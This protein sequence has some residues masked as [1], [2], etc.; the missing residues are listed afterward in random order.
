MF[1]YISPPSA[2]SLGFS[3]LRWPWMVRWHHVHVQNSQQHHNLMQMKDL[4]QLVNEVEQNIVICPCRRQRQIIDLRAIYKSWYYATTEFNNNVLSFTYHIASFYIF[5][6]S[7][8]ESSAKRAAI[9]YE[10]E[11]NAH[12]Q[13][14][15]CSWGMFLANAHAQTIICTQLF[16]DKLTNQNWE[17]NKVND[18]NNN[19]WLIVKN[20]ANP[21]IWHGKRRAW[22]LSNTQRQ[23]EIPAMLCRYHE[24]SPFY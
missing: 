10:V 14:I 12:A 2:H 24:V 18:K 23:K 17:N 20:T 9:V 19:C 8:S 3:P 11:A 6:Y 1:Y 4:N 21:N 13:S 22:E 15:I 7:F 16:A 5:L